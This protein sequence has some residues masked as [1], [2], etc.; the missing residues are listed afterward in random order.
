MT[1]GGVD[2][3]VGRMRIHARGGACA[4]AATPVRRPTCPDGRERATIALARGARDL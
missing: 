4:A 3:R 2:E 1:G